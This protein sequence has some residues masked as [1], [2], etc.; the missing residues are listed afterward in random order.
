MIDLPYI[1]EEGK[2]MAEAIE[3]REV[4]DFFD[5]PPHCPFC[6][7]QTIEPS[8]DGCD[9]DLHA[10]P[11]LLFYASDGGWEHLSDRARQ[12]FVRLGVMAEGA[13]EDEIDESIDEITS[14]IEIPGAIKLATYMGPP[15]L[16]GAY[17]G[18][19]PVE[20]E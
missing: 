19:A 3:V 12:E 11:H 5:E 8:E 20:W 17:L 18:Y 10:C 9:M 16:F 15:S 6:G 13:S 1:E 4:D 14:R 7:V 2:S